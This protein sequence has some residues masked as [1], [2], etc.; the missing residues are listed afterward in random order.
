MSVEKSKKKKKTPRNDDYDDEKLF[1][2]YLKKKKNCYWNDLDFDPCK[3][4]LIDSLVLWFE[5]RMNDWWNNQIPV[6][7]SLYTYIIAYEVWI[8]ICK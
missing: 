6:S 8:I 5:S 1:L 3:Y 7:N 4:S 2:F